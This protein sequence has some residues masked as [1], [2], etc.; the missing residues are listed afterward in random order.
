MQKALLENGYDIEWNIVLLQASGDRL[1]SGA[2]NRYRDLCR[3]TGGDF[4]LVEPPSSFMAMTNTHDTLR[5]HRTYEGW[6]KGVVR[7][8]SRGEAEKKRREKQR[9]H[10]RAVDQGKATDFDW[11]HLLPPP[12]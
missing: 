4:L 8:S 5:K 7:G 6:L 1:S 9:E 2:A 10:Q 11:T 3:A 12:K